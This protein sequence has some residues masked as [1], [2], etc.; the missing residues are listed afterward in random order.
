MIEHSDEEY[1]VNELEAMEEVIINISDDNTLKDLEN[2]YGVCG[3]FRVL[4]REHVIG[5]VILK[6][7][8]TWLYIPILYSWYIIIIPFDALRRMPM[9][10]H[11]SV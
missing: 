4:R 5:A 1:M 2:N 6:T 8:V 9:R 7:P 3:G 10:L 11:Y